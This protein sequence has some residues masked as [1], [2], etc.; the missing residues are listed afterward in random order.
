M[1]A[2]PLVCGA[3][4]PPTNAQATLTK[5]PREK[6]TGL[7]GTYHGSVFFENKIQRRGR[8]LQQMRV[9]IQSLRAMQ[10]PFGKVFWYLEQRIAR[11]TD[12]IERCAQ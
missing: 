12:E 11:L 6:L 2:S 8:S 5:G 4:G 9:K 3:A 1:N 10:A 7:S